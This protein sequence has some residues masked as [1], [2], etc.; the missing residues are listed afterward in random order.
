MSK[1]TIVVEGIFRSGYERHFSEYSSKVRAYLMQHGAEVI[2]RQ[3]VKRTLY[4]SS[5][6]DLI[7]LIDFPSMETAEKVFFE[8]GY[9]A[10]IPLRDLVFADFKMYVAEYGDI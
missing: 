9:L 7:M 4:G 1:A 5:I 10:L 6:C 8:P 2:R 3:Q